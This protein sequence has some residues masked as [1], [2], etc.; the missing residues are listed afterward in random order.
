MIEQN[1]QI[2]LAKRAQVAQSVISALLSRQILPTEDM[3]RRLESLG[4]VPT[5]WAEP[6]AKRAA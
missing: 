6:I 5:W 4:I 1:T 3:A 2:G